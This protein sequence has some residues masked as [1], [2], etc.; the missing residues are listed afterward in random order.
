MNQHHGPDDAN[1]GRRQL[2]FGAALAAGGAVVAGCT[3]NEPPPTTTDDNEPAEQPAGDEPGRQVT[4]GFSAPAADHGW[5]AAITRNAD[6]QAKTYSD[7][8]LEKVEATN[9]VAK[10]IAAVETLI[11]KQVDALVILPNDGKQLT[12]VAQKATDAGIPVINLDRIFDTPLSYRCWIG[13]DNYGMGVA[14]ANFIVERLDRDGVQNPVIAEIAGIDSLP[15]TQERSQGF[16]DA[17]AKA[18]LE[19]K[20]RVA[21]DFTVPG[22]QK[23]ASNLLQAA[24]KIDALWNHDDDQGIGVL[25]AIDQ[26]GRDEFFMVGGAGS[27]DMMER[28]K[29]DNTVIKCTVTYNPSMASSAVSLARLVAQ[30]KGMTDLVENEIPKMITLA[31]ATITKSNVDDYMSLGF[32]S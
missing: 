28:I 14:A 20:N 22:G 16:E 13:G 7:V 17:L 23:A 3:S 8:S 30:G 6:S 19:V 10:Q 31:S 1:L 26:A 2:F 21:A 4:I 9:D 24:P 12:A 15:L 27:T 5:I 18:G 25:A 11:N 29:A 32:R